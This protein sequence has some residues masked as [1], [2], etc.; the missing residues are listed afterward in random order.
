MNITNKNARLIYNALLKHFKADYFY[1][2]YQQSIDGIT[3]IA[4]INGIR[5]DLCNPDNR[6]IEFRWATQKLIDNNISCYDALVPSFGSHPI[7]SF[8]KTINTSE[9]EIEK[10]IAICLLNLLEQGQIFA[11]SYFKRFYVINTI[12]LEQLLIMMDL[13]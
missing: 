1:L 12:S 9:F 7:W 8:A 2:D 11:K 10:H 5:H 3:S 6:L 13:M 4:Y